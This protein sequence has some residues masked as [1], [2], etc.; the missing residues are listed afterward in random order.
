MMRDHEDAE[1]NSL[2]TLMDEEKSKPYDNLQ[3][4]TL[5]PRFIHRHKISL[6][7]LSLFILLI[8]VLYLVTKAGAPYN[9]CGTT[10][11]EA[12]RRGCVFE[13]TG[14]AWL[15]QACL[16]PTTEDQFLAYIKV[17][18]LTYYRDQECTQLVSLSEVRLGNQGFFVQETYHKTHCAF[19]LRKLHR[20]YIEGK[21]VDGMIMN[22]GH[23]KHCV[24][25]MLEGE[26]MH[27]GANGQFSYLKFPYC[28]KMGG[29]NLRWPDQGT[30]S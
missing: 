1:F 26:M 20:R 5:K 28:G 12:R 19:L 18:N 16:D 10:P 9:H 29:Y 7:V 24:S 8:P 17:H 25:E 15:P 14:F 30:W 22:I 3:N 13:T 11:T 2:T 21:P 6:A 4:S 23:T 27:K